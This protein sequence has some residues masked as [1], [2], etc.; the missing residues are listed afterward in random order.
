M[1]L[2]AMMVQIVLLLMDLAV[3]VVLGLTV[4]L[5][6]DLVRMMDWCRF[7]W[8]GIRVLASFLQAKE[9]REMQAEDQREEKLVIQIFA[10]YHSINIYFLHLPTPQKLM[11]SI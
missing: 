6:M 2:T 3:A 10:K 1:V 5:V 7:F 11:H 8:L 4:V 9:I